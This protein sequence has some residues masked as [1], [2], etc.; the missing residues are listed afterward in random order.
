MKTRHP[1]GATTGWR[2]VR[3]FEAGVEIGAKPIDVSV[4][5]AVLSRQLHDLEP[6]LT[7]NPYDV[8][9]LVGRFDAKPAEVGQLRAAG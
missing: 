2:L 1:A 6:R 4:V 9:G 7:R 5:E 3:A 8:R